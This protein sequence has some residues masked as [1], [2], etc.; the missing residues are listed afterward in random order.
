ME[1]RERAEGKQQQDPYLCS[2]Y[3]SMEGCVDVFV[4]V[5]FTVDVGRLGIS[6]TQVKSL[7]WFECVCVRVS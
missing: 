6:I 5:V 2:C 3:S 4:I 7:I 1:K